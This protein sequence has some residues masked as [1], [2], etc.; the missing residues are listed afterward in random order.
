[1]PEL[2]RFR[3][4]VILMF[5]DEGIHQIAHF[6]VRA[7]GR[8]AS[9]RLD[10]AL[11]AGDLPVPQL[12]LVREWAAL[13]EAELAENWARLRREELPTRIDPLD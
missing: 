12:R 3:G 2:C 7:A 5:A 8:K 13:H 11:L 9:F 4:M 1:M 6:H 10:G